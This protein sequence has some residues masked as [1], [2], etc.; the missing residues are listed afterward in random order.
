M[1]GRRRTGPTLELFIRKSDGSIVNLADAIMN[2]GSGLATLNEV[3]AEIHRGMT[4]AGGKVGTGLADSA[5]FCLVGQNNNPEGKDVHVTAAF[6]ATGHVI[7]RTLG[8]ITGKTG[9]AATGSYNRKNGLTDSGVDVFWGAVPDSGASSIKESFLP[10]GF[11]PL[12]LGGEVTFR[13]ERIVPVGAWIGLEIEN[14]S[15][16]ELDHYGIE[17][18]FYLADPE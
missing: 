13:A 18:D 4:Y 12:A 6:A 3:H 14:V 5:T 11:G 17:W 8:G 15:G 1:G 2:D 16:Q 9:G 10:G 7:V